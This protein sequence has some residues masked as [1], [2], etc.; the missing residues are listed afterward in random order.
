ML[1]PK[2][3]GL[4]CS[5]PRVVSYKARGEATQ[6]CYKA[7]GEG[8][9]GLEEYQNT[10]SIQTYQDQ[11]HT[12]NISY[13]QSPCIART[14]SI[15]A[16]VRDALLPIATIYGSPGLDFAPSLVALGVAT[17]LDFLTRLSEF[18]LRQ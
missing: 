11:E 14:F 9:W 13:N 5:R 1:S 12:T 2:V 16:I 4:A 17:P 7:V 18:L 3:E 8:S 10:I 6:D 15:V